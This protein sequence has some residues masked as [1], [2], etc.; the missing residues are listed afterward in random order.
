L[1]KEEMRQNC[2]KSDYFKKCQ[3]LLY[4]YYKTQKSSD[5][6][7]GEDIIVWIFDRW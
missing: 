5:D 4:R 3:A 6:Y 1:D 2:R 7:W